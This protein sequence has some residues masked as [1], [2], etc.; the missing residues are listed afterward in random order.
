[1]KAG[2]GR[3]RRQLGQPRGIGQAGGHGQ[4]HFAQN[5]LADFLHI[6]FRRRVA[7]DV[8]VH[9]REIEKAFVNR[10]RHERRRIFFEHVEHL[11]PRAAVFVVVRPAQNAARTKPLRLETRH[12]GF[13]AEFFR[14]AIGRDDDAVAAPAAADPDGTALQFLIQRDFATREEAVAVHVQDAIG[15][16]GIHAQILIEPKFRPCQILARRHGQKLSKQNVSDRDGV[17]PIP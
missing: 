3:V 10:D 11:L 17:F 15:C 4:F 6:F 14:R 12:A 8:P 16:F 5:P 7:P 2:L 1:M 13:D 9:R